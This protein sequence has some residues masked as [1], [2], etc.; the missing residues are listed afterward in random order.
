M[1]FVSR[2]LFSLVAYCL[3]YKRE[4]ECL[5]LIACIYTND[6][7]FFL[8]SKYNFPKYNGNYDNIQDHLKPSIKKHHFNSIIAIISATCFVM[9]YAYTFPILPLGNVLMSLCVRTLNQLPICCEHQ[10]LLSL[11]AKPCKILR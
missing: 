10:Y 8:P 6:I 9:L 11:C 5:K 4:V 7:L 1:L 2:Y 3:I